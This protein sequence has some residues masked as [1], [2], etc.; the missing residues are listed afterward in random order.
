MDV[1]ERDWK[2]LRTL[3][4]AALERYCEQ[5]LNECAS[6]LAETERTAHERY[7]ALFEVMRTRDATLGRIFD[8]LRRSTAVTHLLRMKSEG[9]VTH[10]EMQAFSPPLRDRVERWVERR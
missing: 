5:V 3:H 4:K 7:L 6:I 1:D 2:A 9:L 10:D 8:D